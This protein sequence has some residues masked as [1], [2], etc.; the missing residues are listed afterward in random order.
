MMEGK[1]C[2]ILSLYLL[3]HKLATIDDPAFYV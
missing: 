1:F 2:F 3:Q